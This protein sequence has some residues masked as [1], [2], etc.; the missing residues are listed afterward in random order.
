MS[1]QTETRPP[2]DMMTEAGQK[3]FASATHVN[4]R[5]MCGVLAMQK[6]MLDFVSRRIERDLAAAE[7][8]AKAAD[9]PEI[10]AVTQ[11]FC[12]Q[13][14]SDYADESAEFMRRATAM[15]GETFAATVPR[16]GAA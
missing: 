6:H 1:T 8:L 2:F 13:A 5:A 16:D 3:A 10:A 11:E 14:M 7:A 4:A 9:A 12:T 15:A